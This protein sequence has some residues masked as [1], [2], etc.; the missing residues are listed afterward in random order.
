MSKKA[1]K[2]RPAPSGYEYRVLPIGEVR[3]EEPKNGDKAPAGSIGKRLTGYAAKFNT[4]SVLLFGE[5][6]EEIAPGAF[7]QSLAEEAD[8]RFT[9]NHDQNVV[10][11]RNKAGTLEL[12]ED[13]VGLA[14][15]VWPPDTYWAKDLLVSVERGDVNQGSFLFRTIKDDWREDSET[16]LLIR[17]LEN[18]ALRDVSLV[19]YPAYEDTEAEVRS[20]IDEAKAKFDAERTARVKANLRNIELAELDF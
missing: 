3:A 9:F 20:R 10:L 18:V 5:F 1:Q 4:R 16:G 7:T 8:I 12:R 14:F 17:T 6:Y 2:T 19:T 13:N 15:S 11:G